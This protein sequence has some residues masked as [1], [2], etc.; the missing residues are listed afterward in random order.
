[1]IGEVE[2]MDCVLCEGVEKV[3]NG[4]DPFFI[5]ELEAGYATL[6]W[7]QR[8][9]GY[10]LFISKEHATELH[11]LSF[12][13]KM[14]YLEEM[15]I[16]SEAIFNVFKPKKMNYELLGNAYAHMHWH[17]IPRYAGD[18]LENEPVWRLPKDEMYDEKYRPSKSEAKE[19][20]GLIRNEIERLLKVPKQKK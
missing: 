3:R 5:I 2:N 18:P 16:V 14:K 8:Y 11:E 13:M 19:I 20:A 17:L 10:T 6:R 9:K 12:D 15:A 4:E 1:M 7:Y